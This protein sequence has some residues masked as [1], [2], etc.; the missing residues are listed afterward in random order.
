VNLQDHLKSGKEYGNTGF[1]RPCSKLVCAD[2]FQVSVQASS[3]H[4][5][6]PQNNS[7]PYI[8]VELGYPSEP[9]EA[10]MEYAEDPDRPTDTVYGHVPIEWVVQVL[11]QHGGIDWAE[12]TKEGKK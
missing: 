12:T 7:G 10:W 4:Y 2:G 3:T 9:V 5:C 8:D 11:D 6:T 1:R